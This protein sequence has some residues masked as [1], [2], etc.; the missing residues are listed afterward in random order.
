[1]KSVKLLINAGADLNITCNAGA[2]PLINAAMDYEF[3]QS[4]EICLE[5][6]LYAGAKVNVIDTYG[7]AV[8]NHMIHEHSQTGQGFQY[9][10]RTCK[11]LLAA[12]ETKTLPRSE[13]TWF[14]HMKADYSEFIYDRY[15]QPCLKNLCR[16]AI[17]KQMLEVDDTNLFYRIG[18]LGLPSS[19][20]AFIVYNVSP[21]S[22]YDFILN[23]EDDSDGA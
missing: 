8:Q 14:S 7:N 10:E 2:T 13:F 15:R 20:A 12:G 1:M 6:L 16:D 17:R 21:P 23:S 9:N 5:I 18:K 11:L 22:S 3:T 4:G 19:L